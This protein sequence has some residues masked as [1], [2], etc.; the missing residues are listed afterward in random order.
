METASACRPLRVTSAFDAAA[1]GAPTHVFCSRTDLQEL[2]TQ[3]KKAAVLEF[4]L[5]AC[6]TRLLSRMHA[7][8]TVSK[9]HCFARS[10]M[11]AGCVSLWPGTIRS[12]RSFADAGHGTDKKARN[13]HGWC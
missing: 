9:R 12:R 3:M 2:Q 7:A 5:C 8:L 4:G 11:G 1:I 10:A 13:R 6:R